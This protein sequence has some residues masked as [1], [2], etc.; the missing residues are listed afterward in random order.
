MIHGRAMP[1]IAG[2]TGEAVMRAAVE[3]ADEL[4]AAALIVPTSTGGAR[5]G[6]REVPPPAA[7]HRARPP[8]GRRGPAHARVGRLPDD[9]STAENVDEMIDTALVT[10]RDCAGP[11]DRGAGRA[12]RGAP[13]GHAGRHEPGDGARDPRER[14]APRPGRARAGRARPLH[15]GA[16][17]GSRARCATP[18]LAAAMERVRG[19]MRTRACRPAATRSATS[20]GRRGAGPRADDRLA[21]G[22][23]GRRRPLR[24]HPRRAGRPRSGRGADRRRRSRS[25]RSPTRRACASSRRSSAA[26]RSSGSSTRAARLRDADGVWLARRARRTAGRAAVRRRSA[27]TSRSTSSRARCS[28]PRTCRSASSPRSPA[29]RASTSSSRARPA[30]RG[31]RRWRLRRDALGA[32]AEFVLA[33]ERAARDAAGA[34]GHRRRA[35]ASRTAPCNVIPGRVERTLDVRHAGRRGPRAAIAALRAEAEAI[36]AAPRRSP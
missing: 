33:A 3:L 22:L 17:R 24:R 28:R 27:R 10:A 12:H 5:A 8:A 19:W 25:S 11:A 13:N 7:D 36:C 16:R 23:G 21:P 4:D 15:R 1:V 14:R 31:R 30:T 32:A 26:A 34:G 29:R 35:R 2:V 6:L 9:M 20:P 18:A